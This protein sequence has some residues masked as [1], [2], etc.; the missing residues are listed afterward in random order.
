MEFMDEQKA[1]SQLRRLKGFIAALKLPFEA[2]FLRPDD[3]RMEFFLQHT[4]KPFPGPIGSFKM[5]ICYL[6][7]YD[8]GQKDNSSKNTPLLKTTLQE[9]QN[10]NA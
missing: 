9:R 8:E 5:C 6:I 10:I 2:S 7:G 3:Y 1:Q 4:A